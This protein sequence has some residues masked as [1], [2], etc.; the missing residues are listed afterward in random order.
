[1]VDSHV[2]D[3]FRG[4]VIVMRRAQWCHIVR[5]AIVVPGHNLDELRTQAQQVVPAIEPE[6][7]A[8][9]Q[10]LARLVLNLRLL[11]P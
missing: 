8:G 1:M 3:P 2:V 7:V 5:L 11:C 10:N 9:F 4:P 6:K